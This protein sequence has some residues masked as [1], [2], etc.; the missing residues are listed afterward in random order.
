M[1]LNNILLMIDDEPGV[2]VDNSP[3]QKRLRRWLTFLCI[4]L[5]ASLLTACDSSG[6]QDTD[7]SF[8][9]LAAAV[10][11]WLLRSKAMTTMC[12]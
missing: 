4:P 8:Q 11:V 10:R 7:P 6:K 12:A 3:H 9:P 5:L 2:I 1:L